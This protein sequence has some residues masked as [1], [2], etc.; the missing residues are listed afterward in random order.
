MLVASPTGAASLSLQMPS[1]ESPQPKVRR[2]RRAEVADARRAA[3]PKTV[4]ARDGLRHWRPN[5]TGLQHLPV[6][7]CAWSAI[8]LPLQLSPV[9][10][11]WID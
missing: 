2:L 6:W 5:V 3:E 7:F 4:A 1:A 9:L 11:G 10:G 8:D